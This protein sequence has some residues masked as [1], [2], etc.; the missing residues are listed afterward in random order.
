M[1][2]VSPDSELEPASGKRSAGMQ[3]EHS[4]RRYV[5]ERACPLSL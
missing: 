3:R 5:V 4:I 2:T 1:L